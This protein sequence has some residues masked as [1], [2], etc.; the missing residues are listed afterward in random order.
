MAGTPDMA[1]CFSTAD[2]GGTQMLPLSPYYALNHHF[3]MLLGVD[4]FQT[5]QAYHRAKTRLHNAWLHGEGVV[6]GFGVRLDQPRNEIRV[7]PGLALDCAGHEL[8]L[9]ADACVNIGAWFEEHR[10]DPNLELSE[11]VP[12]DGEGELT[13]VQFTAHVVIRFKACLTRQVPAILEPCDSSGTDTAYSRVFETVEIFLRPGPAP[14]KERPYHRVRL[15]FGLDAPREEDGAVVAADQDVIDARDD[16]AA[17]DLADREQTCLDALRKFAALDEIDMG[18][19][20][21]AADGTRDSLFPR[22]EDEPVVLADVQAITLERRSEGW[23][24]T[25]GAVDTSVRPTHIATSTLQELPCR[26]CETAGGPPSE[27]ESAGP[28]VDAASVSVGPSQIELR[29]DKALDPRSVQPAAFSVTRLGGNGW[30]NVAVETS[31]FEASEKV[32]KLTLGAPGSATPLPPNSFVRVIAKG[33]GPSPLV[34]EGH[35]PL[36]GAFSDPPATQH[37]GRDFV[38]M[39]QRS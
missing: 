29:V 12:A 14:A 13:K 34:G 17:A 4:D 36:A 16:L 18:P 10:D 5:E 39:G 32:V 35:V 24:A 6:W 2:A 7:L 1:S 23:A 31:A 20:A 3:G 8:H 28:R 38:F 26:C 27:D 21:S 37:D 9:D 15:L 19:A 11:T 33:T 30:K 22:E 25:A